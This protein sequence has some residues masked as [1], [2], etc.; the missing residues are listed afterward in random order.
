MM[1]EERDKALHDMTFLNARV[2]GRMWA[3]ARA[4]CSA[5]LGRRLGLKLG[6]SR[7]QP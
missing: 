3:T 7:T 1:E 6:L 5:K 2:K 4:R